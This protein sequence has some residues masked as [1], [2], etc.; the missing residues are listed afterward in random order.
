MV[1]VD[2]QVNADTERTTG[3]RT[4]F[5]TIEKTPVR[6]GQRL[7]VDYIHSKQMSGT[8]KC[9]QIFGL[10]RRLAI[11]CRK[12]GECCRPGALLKKL[13]PFIERL[14]PSWFQC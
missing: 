8:R 10:K 2:H 6:A 5:A 1:S 9:L 3:G 12:S 7:C 11:R 14:R 13:A 4:R